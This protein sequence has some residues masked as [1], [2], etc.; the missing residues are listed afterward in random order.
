M[1]RMYIESD[2]AQTSKLYITSIQSE[3]EGTFTCTARG[4]A[5]QIR[6]S[7]QLLL[8]SKHLPVLAK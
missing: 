6:K 5:T 8:F 3:D 1:C 2:D 4:P 7:V